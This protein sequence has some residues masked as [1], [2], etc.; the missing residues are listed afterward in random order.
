M[1]LSLPIL[2]HNV[3]VWYRTTVLNGGS[4]EAVQS[5]P[6]LHHVGADCLAE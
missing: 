4:M 3:A 2:H 5:E 6:M 1:C